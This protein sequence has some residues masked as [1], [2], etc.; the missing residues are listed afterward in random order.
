MLIKVKEE[1][2]QEEAG[3]GVEVVDNKLMIRMILKVVR[4][5]EEEDNQ[6]QEVVKVVVEEEVAEAVGNEQ[7]SQSKNLTTQ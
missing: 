4:L 7:E 2:M 1:I 6:A 3:V 5:P